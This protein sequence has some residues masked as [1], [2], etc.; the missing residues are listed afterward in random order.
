MLLSVTTHSLFTFSVMMSVTESAQG[1]VHHRA[2]IEKLV[3]SISAISYL[4][5]KCYLL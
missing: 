4:L 5:S 3:E 1:V 2:W